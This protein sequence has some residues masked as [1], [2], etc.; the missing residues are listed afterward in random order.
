MSEE[1]VRRILAEYIPPLTRDQVREIAR[2]I[3][4]YYDEQAKAAAAKGPR[5][6]SR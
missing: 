4:N 6:K 3:V 5:T 1:A 2:N